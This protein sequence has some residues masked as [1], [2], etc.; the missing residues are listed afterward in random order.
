MPISNIERQIRF[1]NLSLEDYKTLSQ[2]Y[3]YSLLESLQGDSNF[4]VIYESTNNYIKPKAELKREAEKLSTNS[5]KT[6]A[7]FGKAVIRFLAKGAK[8][9]DDLCLVITTILTIGGA[10][11]S[12]CITL[13]IGIILFAVLVLPFGIITNGLIKIDRALGKIANPNRDKNIEKFKK[14]SKNIQSQTDGIK[15][16]NDLE[17]LIKVTEAMDIIKENPEM[18]AMTESADIL[19]IISVIENKIE[20]I[21]SLSIDNRMIVYENLCPDYM[22]YKFPVT[23]GDL[24]FTTESLLESV[25]VDDNTELFMTLENVVSKPLLSGK[26]LLAG[27][28]AITTDVCNEKTILEFLNRYKNT[29]HYELVNESYNDLPILMETGLCLNYIRKCCYDVPEVLENCDRFD[30]LL[31]EIITEEKSSVYEEGT[32]FNP[33][34]CSLGSLTPFPVADRA[35]GNALCEIENAE[36]DDEITEAMINFGRLASAISESY[37]IEEDITEGTIMI[38][39]EDLAKT[40]RKVET[41][42]QEKFAKRATKDESNTV[43]AAVKHAIDPMEKWIQDK[44]NKIKEADMNERKK[45]VMAGGGANRIISKVWRW[46]K[47][48]VGLLIGS[49][50]GA[51]IPAAALITGITF[52]GYLCTDAFLDRKARASILRDLEDEIMICNEKIDDSR[53]DDNK[54]KKYELMRIRN[55]LERQRDKI[56][57]GLEN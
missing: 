23:E 34:P 12:T 18:I 51:Y 9:F 40:A 42:S 15:D 7:N 20:N 19:R 37:K 5:D 39:Q 47:R 49:V 44:Y 27:M 21:D 6:V 38:I 11:L 46:V 14:L 36:T 2:H 43:K 35:V 24:S 50:V 28:I 26:G 25:S 54:Q 1:S 52:I 41:K 56:K 33:D 16:I 13:I 29:V 22:S 32:G 55:S 3:N 48:G 57:Y 31:G 30:Q 8:A 17:K 10:T 45:M 4:K 53:G